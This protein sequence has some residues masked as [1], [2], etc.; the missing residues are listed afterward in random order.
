MM[1]LYG[2]SAD[3]DKAWLSYFLG[4]FCVLVA[5]AGLLKGRA[6]RFCGSVVGLSVFAF[7]LL[8]LAN[9]LL[10]GPFFSDSRSKPSVLNA[11]MFMLVFGVPGLVYA[12]KAKFGFGKSGQE[13][14]VPGRETRSPNSDSR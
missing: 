1:F 9:E 6:A 10:S 12:I 7:G 11:I 4:A 8:Y 3:P 14:A 13:V 2:T 5:M